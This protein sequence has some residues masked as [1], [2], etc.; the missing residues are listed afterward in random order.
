MKI[1]RVIRKTMRKRLTKEEVV[2]RARETHGDKYDYSEF[3]K[4]DFIFSGKRQ[5]IPI[6]CHEKDKEGNEHGIFWQIAQNHYKRNGCPKC[7]REQIGYKRSKIK[8]LLKEG[9]QEKRKNEI[10]EKSK[11]A[12]E[13]E[14]DYSLFLNDAFVYKG[15]KYKIPIICHNRF[16]DGKEHG[17]FWQT[18][19]NHMKGQDCP[20]CAKNHITYTTEAY[21]KA[22][23]KIHG[24]KY[25]YSKTVYNGAHNYITFTCP[26]HGDI[27]M[28]AY[29]HLQG[30]GCRYCAGT[31]HFTR[32]EFI[33]KAREVHGD[34]YDYSKVEYINTNTKV[35]IICPKH[36]EFW[37]TPAHHLSG[38]GCPFCNISHLER[39]MSQFLERHGIEYEREK[40]FEWLKWKKK[41]VM[42]LDFYL[43]QYNVGIECQ[44]IQHF[45]E[46]KIYTTEIVEKVKERDKVKR[47]KCNEHGVELFYY[48]E[49]KLNELPYDRIYTKKKEIL[50]E[51]LKLK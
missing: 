34:K 23:K 12:H 35:C 32:E 2:E 46:D 25:D 36:G 11:D 21:I 20:Y 24:E 18:A 7:N 19:N 6:I 50:K 22:C 41:G 14:Y 33:K 48:T 15:N 42:K 44:G 39:K 4:D 27:S 1:M 17:V 45:K 47:D 28:K 38:V 10:V 8:D 31:Y 16:D 26:I 49:I 9:I 5:K 29:S 40:T 3:L 37:Q 51:I 13:L 30:N 43:P